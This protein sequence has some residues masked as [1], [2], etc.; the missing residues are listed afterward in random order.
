PIVIAILVTQCPARP[1]GLP[2]VD[3][4]HEVLDVTPP[5]PR[6]SRCAPCPNPLLDKKPEREARARHVPSLGDRCRAAMTLEPIAHYYGS[7]FIL[8]ERRHQAGVSH[9]GIG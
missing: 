2:A 8:F 4:L 1:K 6:R 7:R 5:Q 9:R 3:D